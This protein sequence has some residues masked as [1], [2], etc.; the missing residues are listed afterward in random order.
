MNGLESTVEGH[1]G[2]LYTRHVRGFPK[3]V[4]RA[5]GMAA[6]T[7]AGGLVPKLFQKQFN[8]FKGEI[9]FFGNNNIF[10]FR[11]DVPNLGFCILPSKVASNT[12]FFGRLWT[13]LAKTLV[14]F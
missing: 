6:L 1:L 10:I 12:P 5:T 9:N 2:A 4:N 3:R 7:A 13:D 8:R 11:G 14:D